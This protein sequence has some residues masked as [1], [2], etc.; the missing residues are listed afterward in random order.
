[1]KFYAGIGSRETPR[2]VQFLMK[3]ISLELEKIG[4]ILRS[5]H[6]PGADQA[7]ELGCSEEN[8]RIYLP[9]KGWLGSKSNLY[10]YDEEAEKS[11]SQFHPAPHKIKKG[12]VTALMARNYYQIMGRDLEKIKSSFV[13]CWTKDGKDSG[14]TGQAL[15]IANHE[16][17]KIF[18]L[19]SCSFED[20][21]FYAKNN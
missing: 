3:R 19:Y 5:G 16:G 9:Y 18:N 2:N 7:F 21:L 6:A 10:G 4:Y 12:I 11:I 13:V 15:R 14:G 1:M 8:S 20:V 17:I